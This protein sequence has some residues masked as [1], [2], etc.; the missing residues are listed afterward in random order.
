MIPAKCK[1]VYNT[2][3][4]PAFGTLGNIATSRLKSAS[5]LLLSRIRTK[6]DSGSA[7]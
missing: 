6:I 5:S 3:T 1:P 2:G 7:R 4:Q